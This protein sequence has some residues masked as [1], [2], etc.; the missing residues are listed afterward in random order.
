M[1][2]KKIMSDYTAEEI[3]NALIEMY[4]E[5]QDQFDAYYKVI[6]LVGGMPERNFDEFVIKVG[7]IDPAAH[8][9]AYEEEIDEEAYLS[10]SGYSV[11]EDLNFALGFAKW[12]E[13]VNASILLD[14]DL[15]LSTIDLIALCIYEMTFYGFDQEAIKAELDALE[16]GITTEMF[17]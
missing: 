3:L 8:D 4:P 17:H 5:C 12:E 14:E 9:E 11:K 7:I 1:T 13:W 15:E 10:I 16:Q 2:L 6:E